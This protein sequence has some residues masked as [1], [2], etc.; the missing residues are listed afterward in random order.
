MKCAGSARKATE[1]LQAEV[2]L[3]VWGK[4]F[5]SFLAPEMASKTMPG[6]TLGYTNTEYSMSCAASFFGA[7]SSVQ[8]RANFILAINY[9]T[10]AYNPSNFNHV[11][12]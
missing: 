11:F 6:M 7:M 2:G 12:V 8:K 5:V 4:R 1:G 3:L 10:S 9:T